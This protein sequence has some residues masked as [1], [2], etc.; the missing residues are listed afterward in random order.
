LVL[1][2]F[3]LFSFGTFLVGMFAGFAEYYRFAA[4]DVAER[5]FKARAISWVIAGGVVAAFLGPQLAR[6]THD[7]VG[8]IPFLGSYMVIGGLAVV[9]M[10]LIAYLD[11]PLPTLSKIREGGRPLRLVARQPALVV[12]ILV[13]MIGAGTMSLLMTATPLAMIG[14]GLLI[15]DASFVIQWHMLAMFAPAFFTGNFIQR[16][17][18]VSVMMVGVIMLGASVTAALSGTQIVHFWLALFALGLGWNFTWVGA[19][20]LL[21][22]TY[23]LSE[24]GKV[25]ALHDFM[26]FGTVALASLTSGSILYFFDWRAVNLIA[27]PAIAIALIAIVWLMRI[28]SV[29]D[30]G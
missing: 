18:V 21:T 10:A 15:S 29:P 30:T 4:A 26:V 22:E 13:G 24:R 17:G 6:G 7:L 1:S 27:I 2:H 5:D 19:S 8:G 14:H 20:T 28:R 11:I 3:W 25:Q 12:A 16:F 9:S 23:E